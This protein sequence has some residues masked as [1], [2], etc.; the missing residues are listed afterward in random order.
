MDHGRFARAMRSFLKDTRSDSIELVAN[1]DVVVAMFRGSRRFSVQHGVRK[2]NDGKEA[3]VHSIPQGEI[4]LYGSKTKNGVPWDS[5]TCAF[6][7]WLLFSK[8]QVMKRFIPEKCIDRVSTPREGY[9]V[10][11]YRQPANHGLSLACSIRVS[12]DIDD[13]TLMD[14]HA[15]ADGWHPWTYR[16]TETL[17]QQCIVSS[18]EFSVELG[19]LI[20]EVSRMSRCR[21]SVSVALGPVQIIVLDCERHGGVVLTGPGIQNIQVPPPLGYVRAACK[22]TESLLHGLAWKPGGLCFLVESAF[23]APLD[24]YRKRNTSEATEDALRA[25]KFCWDLCSRLGSIS[26]TE[27]CISEILEGPK[28]SPSSMYVIACHYFLFEPVIADSVVISRK[29]FGER[30]QDVAQ[31]ILRL[32]THDL[33]PAI[34][35]VGLP[36]DL[37]ANLFAILRFWKCYQCLE[38]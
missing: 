38:I 35:K 3:Q 36:D 14:I 5:M 8:N 26:E 2:K 16:V 20:R 7:G 10:R 29:K 18:V 28:N 33:V 9:Q 24:A 17:Y 22:A 37:K 30:N 19:N 12:K 6:L 32:A 27:A 13:E 23:E 1:S 25:I 15:L 31:K 21:V 11:A 4:R 34:A